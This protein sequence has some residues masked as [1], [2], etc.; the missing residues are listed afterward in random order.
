MAI[1]QELK[2]KI[3][4]TINAGASV[5]QLRD[6]KKLL[7]EIPADAAEFKTVNR[8]IN[9]TTDVVKGAKTQTQDFVDTLASAP[10]PLGMLGRGID[11]VSSSTNKFGLA[12]KAT[13]IGLVVALIAQLVNAFTSNEKAMKKLEPV[14]IGFE[15]ILGGIF[16]ALEPVFDLVVDLAL[17]GMPYLIKAIGGLYAAFAGLR[18]F[19][20]NFFVVQF[21]LFQSFG[22]VLEGVFTLD[23]KLIKEGVT[24]AVTAVKDGVKNVIQTTTD[25]YKRFET[26]TQELTKTEKKNLAERTEAQQKALEKQKALLTQAEKDRQANLDKQKAVNMAAAKSE[27][28]K[29]AIEKQYALDSYNSKKKLL[30][31]QAKLYP[32][33]SAEYKEFQSQLTALD[34]DYINK[35]TEFRNKDKELA[36][37]AFQDEV[38][39]SQ[40]ANKEKLADLTNTY[41]LIKEQ[42]GENSKEA[43]DAQD[44]IFAAQAEGLAN[45]RKLYENKKELTKEEIAR[46]GEIK[47]AEENLTVTKQLENIKRAKSDLDTLVK[48]NETDKA[49]RDVDFQ[50]RMDAAALDLELQGK[51][52]EEKKIADEKYYA[53]QLILLQGQDEKIAQLNAKRLE[54]QA[55]YTEGEILLEQK[56]VAAKL[57]TLDNI[58]AL[59]G[60]ESAVGRAALVAKQILLAK[61]LVMEAKKTITFATLKASEATVATATGA[62]K[63]AAVGFPQ[64]IPL[65][66]AYAVQAAGIISAIVSAVRG[67]KSAAGAVSTGDMGGGAGAAPAA[68]AQQGTAVPRPRGMA[69]GGLVRGAGGGKS[70]LIPAMLSNGESVINANSTAMFAPLLSSINAIGGGKRFAEGGLA[71]G[72]LGQTQALTALSSQ[73]TGNMAPIKTYVV[74]SDMTNQQM[75]DRS[76]KDRSTL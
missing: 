65:L 47:Q 24:D 67:A 13:G 14:M 75:L 28:E 57:S 10:G 73:M 21:K 53:D 35:K 27:E 17:K 30:D 48:K 34:A 71:I 39:M 62:A 9:D 51:I 7:R 54:D 59:A 61:E 76:I 1:T 5:Q 44:N 38:K 50:N 66:I 60:A 3:D 26:G 23:F 36:Q 22:K 49:A 69:T 20:K 72:G 16:T 6:L 55:K 42:Y 46:L 68:P 2:V 70:D 43:R 63:T 41:T 74:A 19:L 18:S 31:D 33:G 12:L 45:E 64:N 25:T 37:K 52:L 40:D 11:T 58:I 29:L 56:R 4:A 8:A 15:K 32:K